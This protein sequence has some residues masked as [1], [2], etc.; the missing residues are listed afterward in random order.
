MVVDGWC[1]AFEHTSRQ[2]YLEAAHRATVWLT[3]DV[4]P[5]GYFR[6]N[7][8]F[9]SKDEIKNYNVLCAWSMYRCGVL[10]EDQHACSCA[11]RVVDAGLR[12]QLENGWFRWNCL[13][14]PGAPLLHT[15]A[16]TLQGVLEVGALAGREDFIQATRRGVDPVLQRMSR[17]GFLPAQFRSDW[18]PAVRSSCLTGSA[19]T[20]IVCYRLAQLTGEGAYRDAANK[21]VNY[22]K[23]VQVLDSEDANLNGA[24][25]GS[26]P[27]FG[28]YMRGGYPNWATKYFLDSLM[29]QMECGG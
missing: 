12:N 23:A 28:P 9:V 16:Y 15:I 24:L 2:A 19:Q 7:G 26:F 18:T 21:I 14:D 6:T 13:T 27:I 8:Q 1:S 29:L 25:A 10:A 5:D 22:L 4:S 17:K 3:Q 11:V 20:A